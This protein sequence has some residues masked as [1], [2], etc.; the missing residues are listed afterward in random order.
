[1]AAERPAAYAVLV[2]LVL[3]VSDQ[4]TL[5]MRVEGL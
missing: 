1:V 3:E 5:R 2:G 4:V